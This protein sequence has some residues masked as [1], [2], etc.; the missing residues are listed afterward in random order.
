MTER[1]LKATG[2]V[3]LTCLSVVVLAPLVLH[4]LPVL[5]LLA[6]LAWMVATLFGWSKYR[7][8]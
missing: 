7:G 8:Y 3:A 4:V 2:A 5:L 6:L 1:L